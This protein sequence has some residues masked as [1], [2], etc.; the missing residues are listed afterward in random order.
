[1]LLGFVDAAM[2]AVLAPSAMTL[3]MDVVG[4]EKL[5]PALSID[6]VVMGAAGIMAPLAAGRI[7]DTFDIAWAY[8]FVAACQAGRCAACPQAAASSEIRNR[9]F[10]AARR[11]DGRREVRTQRANGP[12][13]VHRHSAH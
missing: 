8:V 12:D 9:A 5:L 7:V 4:K 6:Q 1:M 11:N 2:L 3:V 13:T 10:I